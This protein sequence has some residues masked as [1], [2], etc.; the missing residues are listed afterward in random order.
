M[1]D[2]NGRATARSLLCQKVRRPQLVRFVM[3]SYTV[4]PRVAGDISME[5]DRRLVPLTQWLRD[6]CAATK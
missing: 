2:C 3:P 6:T 5:G 4:R 1:I